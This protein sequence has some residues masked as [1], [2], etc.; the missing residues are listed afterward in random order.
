MR[1]YR[2]M[3]LVVVAML[4]MA[5]MGQP[6]LM[7]FIDDARHQTV[8]VTAVGD[9]IVRVDV[10]PD[11]WNG[12]RLPSLALDKSAQ[13]GK[14]FTQIITDDTLPGGSVERTIEYVAPFDRC[15]REKDYETAWRFFEEKYRKKPEER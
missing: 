1:L 2:L 6:K 12:T 9:D 15:D 8:T 5:A 7:T 14:V 10:V 13:A 3:T 11:G 4:A